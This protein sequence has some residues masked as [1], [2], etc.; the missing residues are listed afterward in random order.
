[1]FLHEFNLKK[2][3]FN[4]NKIIKKNN[5]KII[6]IILSKSIRNQQSNIKSFSLSLFSPP[7]YIRHASDTC[8]SEH[9][10]T[11]SIVRRII[12]RWSPVPSIVVKYILTYLL[13]S[14]TST[15]VAVSDVQSKVKEHHENRRGGHRKR[16]VVHLEFVTQKFE[17][18]TVGTP[19]PGSAYHFHR[20]VF[21]FPDV[22]KHNG[23]QMLNR[24]QCTTGGPSDRSKW[25]G[26]AST[27]E[28]RGS[29]CKFV[30]ITC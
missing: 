5:K 23:S 29:S 25:S 3:R 28:F 22:W 18:H 26:G 4:K 24:W 21:F 11:A 7:S 15:V 19:E 13:T 2:I 17:I 8:C 14:R 10:V 30:L 20:F 12:S 6:P 16:R 9:S 27:S 1:M